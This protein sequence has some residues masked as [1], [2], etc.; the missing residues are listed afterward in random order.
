M[1]PKTSPRSST[2]RREVAVNLGTSQT[3]LKRISK[4]SGLLMLDEGVGEHSSLV[5]VSINITNTLNLF[6]IITKNVI[7]Q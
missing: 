2:G 6:M 5:E 4:Y 7:D 3:S 1:N